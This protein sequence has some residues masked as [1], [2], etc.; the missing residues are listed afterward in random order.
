MHPKR[1][2]NLSL[3]CGA[4]TGQIKAAIDARFGGRALPLSPS[5][6]P[7]VDASLFA[8]L[9]DDAVIDGMAGGMEYELPPRKQADH[10]VHAYWSFVDPLFPVLSKPHFIH[11]YGASFPA[12]RLIPTNEF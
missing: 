1:V 12:S 2:T 6:V 5:A 8:P 7:L 4:F 10:L 11:S 3:A 9:Q